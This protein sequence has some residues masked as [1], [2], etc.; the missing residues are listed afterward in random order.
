MWLII[1]TAWRNLFRQRRR[2]LITVSAMA[3]SLIFAIP[4]YGLTEG[5]N[6]E[7]L[8]GIT[9]MSLGHLQVHNPSYPKGRALS[10]TLKKPGELLKG[11]RA[12][13]QVLAAAARVLGYAL[14]SH[15]RTLEVI[16]EGLP[17]KERLRLGRNIRVGRGINPR[18][19]WRKDH[20]LA[21]ETLVHWKSAKQNGITVGMVLSPKAAR[22]GGA[23]E[24][25]RVVGYTRDSLNGVEAAGKL[26]LGLA[27]EDMKK[28][29]SRARLK[30]G[31]VLR[32][33]A[34]I[35]IVGIEPAQERR[36]TFMADKVKRVNISVPRPPARSWSATAWPTPS[37]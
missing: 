37:I 24:R 2:T 33:S 20:A 19:P 4:L 25:I 29:F 27:L 11:L 31:C 18:A 10:S 15:D 17:E 9:G 12:H 32:H 21:C 7:M 8:K 34:P 28:T 22:P 3:V 36:I 26:V 5:L 1:K 16:M 35:D 13:H 23:C 6:A 30:T 14:A